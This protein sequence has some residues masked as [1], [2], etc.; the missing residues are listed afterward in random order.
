MQVPRQRRHH[1]TS[2][3]AT[4]VASAVV[5]AFSLGSAASAAP[6]DAPGS[7]AA[8]SAKRAVA[9]LVI[10]EPGVSVKRKN[11]DEFKPATDGQNLRVGDAVQTDATGF[12]QIDYAE[13]S[14]TRLD[15]NTTFTIVSLTD[16]EGNRKINGSLESGQ[17]WNRTSALTESE[18][19]EQEGAGATAAV[20]GTAFMVSC[21]TPGN[22]TFTSVVDGV[23]L[24]T[25]DGELQQ[26]D[27]LEECDS[28]EI[29]E[30]DAELCGAPSQVTLDAIIANQ[31]IVENLFFDG[32]AG[33]EGIVLVEDG[34]V[35]SVTPILPADEPAEE[36]APEGPTA[37]PPVVDANPVLVPD[38][39]SSDP[40]QPTPG[41]YPGVASQD[42]RRDV[43]FV[44]QV[45]NPGHTFYIVF[46]ALPDANFGRL[47]DGD[48][49][50]VNTVM[51]YQVT[52]VFTF[53]PVQIEPVCTSEPEELADCF[54]NGI[55]ETQSSPDD[56][57]QTGGPTTYPT[58]ANQPVDNLDGTVSW[59]G[60]FTFKAVNEQGDESAEVTVQLEAVDDICNPGD[61]GPREADA[62]VTGCGGSE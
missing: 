37:D 3:L 18:S 38:P 5:F 33:F 8:Q 27:P 29:D 39:G 36:P 32:L 17:T 52:E 23:Q 40:T 19:F 55:A 48:N 35:V 46:T 13:D 57:T 12:A 6:P 11:K 15:V 20:V 31:W 51:Q 1:F 56:P 30:T 47:L 9:T 16:D 4:A 62:V 28:T 14:F 59:F 22:C 42:E 26:L 54:T 49:V 60:S 61:E 34:E 7:A 25:V 21:T 50:A 41:P 2:A 45:T 58:G 53:D 24:T 43:T 10:I 44:L